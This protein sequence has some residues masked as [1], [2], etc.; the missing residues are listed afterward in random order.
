MIHL[1]CECGKTVSVGEEDAGRRVVCS[2][3][4]G[5]VRVPSRLPSGV[6]PDPVPPPI[7]DFEGEFLED[8]S[9]TGPETPPE[10][11][12][13]APSPK[14]RPPRPA[15]PVASRP[16]PVKV[17]SGPVS[18]TPA[19]TSGMTGE[20]R[21]PLLAF[22]VTLRVMIWVVMIGAVVVPAVLL[23]PGDFG[24]GEIVAS[25][26]A[27]VVGA[28]TAFLLGYLRTLNRSVIALKRGQ[29]EMAR[30]MESGGR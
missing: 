23:L 8:T 22:D 16:K 26:L 3:C 29:R 6:E 14:M 10:S 7:Y 17:R 21:D 5:K 20:R 1:L 12:P 18:A 15:K 28:L 4:G 2:G 27:L 9:Q 30:H 13:K 19:A 25:I 11:P 24:R